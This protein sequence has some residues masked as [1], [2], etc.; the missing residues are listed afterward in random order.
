MVH[1]LHDPV[2]QCLRITHI[3]S[4]ASGTT[5]YDVEL[6]YATTEQVDAMASAAGLRL[7][8]RWHD[9]SGTPATIAST[10]PVSV[11]TG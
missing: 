5:E 6:H 11:Y 4:D 1:S 7:K 3:L 8:E 9:W 2:R 10:D